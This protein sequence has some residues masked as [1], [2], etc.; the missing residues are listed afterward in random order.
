[1]GPWEIAAAASI[2]IYSVLQLLGFLFWKDAWKV[3][4]VVPLFV[5]LGG[6]M[7]VTAI[8]FFDPH[9][10]GSLAPQL[11][12][13]AVAGIA[14]LAAVQGLQMVVRRAGW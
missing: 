2:V 8:H 1:M 3:V 10:T 5:F 4:A 7:T 6:V 9:A 13:L 11:F 14:I 12:W